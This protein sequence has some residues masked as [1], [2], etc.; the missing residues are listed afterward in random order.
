MGLNGGIDDTVFGAPLDEALRRFQEA[1]LKVDGAC[2]PR[3]WP[4]LLR[5]LYPG[6]AEE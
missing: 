1:G 3:T 6:P 4:A 5:G 2:G